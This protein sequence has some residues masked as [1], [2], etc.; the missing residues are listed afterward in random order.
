MQVRYHTRKLDRSVAR[1]N[2][3]KA[4]FVQMNKK[5]D[6]YSSKFSKNWRKYI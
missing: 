1:R 2:M 3:K 4:G 6:D 5:D